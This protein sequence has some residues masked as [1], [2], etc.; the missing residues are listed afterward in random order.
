MPRPRRA[1]T[2]RLRGGGWWEARL[3]PVRCE[4]VRRCCC[5]FGERSIRLATIFALRSDDLRDLQRAASLDSFDSS[6][7]MRL[8]QRAMEDGNPQQAEAALER[9]VQTNPADPAAR[10]A[11]LRLLIDQDRFDEAFD[12]TE[13]S[14][15]YAPKDANL[16]VDRG[17]LA[18]GAA[19]SDQ[20]LA[21]WNQALAVDP[22]QSLAHLYLA[23]ELDR[24]GKAQA[25]GVPLQSFSRKIARAA[26][27]RIVP[28]RRRSSPLCCAW[29]IARRVPRKTE[30]AVRS[31]HLAEKLAAQTSQ[32]K[33]ESVADVNE[34]DAA[35]EDRQFG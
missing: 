8:A 26:V 22:D 9:A 16:L 27:H 33:L 12:L 17:F 3:Q 34:A 4:W 19:H 6:L 10:Q 28:H 11:L 35:G 23:D 30:L 2:S 1:A 32:A 14:L 18:C 20:A 29:R 7:Q 24:E 13:A 5:W 25:C 15:K 31:Y 21:S